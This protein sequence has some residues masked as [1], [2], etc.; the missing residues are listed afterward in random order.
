MCPQAA[1]KRLTNMKKA[2]QGR[3]R[4][5]WDKKAVS[6][7][8][9]IVR[10]FQKQQL[11]N[12]DV[13]EQLERQLEAYHVEDPRAATWEAE[14]AFKTTVEVKQEEHE[15]KAE[16]GIRFQVKP[17][18]MSKQ[19]ESCHLEGRKSLQLADNTRM[20]E[21]EKRKIRYEHHRERVH[22]IH[23][24]R[25]PPDTPG[26]APPQA[27]ADEGVNSPPKSP[28]KKHQ[29]NVATVT[30]AKKVIDAMPM[31]EN[32]WAIKSAPRKD[33][34]KPVEKSYTDLLESAMDVRKTIV[35]DI[36]Q[37]QY[38]T[39][40]FKASAREVD[41]NLQDDFYMMSQFYARRNTSLEDQTLK[42]GDTDF[43]FADEFRT[44]GQEAKRARKELLSALKPL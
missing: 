6:L 9:L 40:N 12:D 38:K 20:V 31:N 5:G 17:V 10:M 42:I 39:S 11:T 41:E 4:R 24:G 15:L 19:L 35:D 37:M 23:E 28:T 13:L 29:K 3:I 27:A 30:V 2:V 33:H 43:S 1:S 22:A 21:A 25:A 14:V 7:H 26:R 36:S 8:E 32:G 18:N 16:C 44:V 34:K